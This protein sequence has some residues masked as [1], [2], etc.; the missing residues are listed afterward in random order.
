MDNVPRAP[1]SGDTIVAIATSPGRGGVGIV[2]VSGPSAAPIARSLLGKLPRPRQ[3]TLRTFRDARNEILDEGLVLY[4][5]GP[6]SFTGE[7][8]L[9]LH[10]HGGPVV[11]DMLVARLL[12]LGARPARPGEFSERA[13]LNGK[14]D[15]IQAEAVADLIA[16][17]SASAARAALRSL[18]GEFSRRVNTIVAD[19]VGLRAQVEAAIDFPEEDI[20]VLGD[21][22][23][24]QQCRGIRAA[25]AAL[26]VP[27]RQGCLLQEGMT[28]VLVGRPNSGKSSLLNAL[29]RYD[30][31]IVSAIPGTTRD[32]LREQIDV[33]GMPLH[34][35][36]T[37]GLRE[38]GD[39]IERE[40]VRR[41]RAAAEEADHVLL[42]VDDCTVGDPA[43]LAACIPDG[44]RHTLVRNK[45]DIT[46][47]KPGAQPPGQHV[48]AAAGTPE[49]AI[50]AMT[51]AGIDALRA[52]LKVCMGFE[53]AGETTFS[54][55]RRHI[56]ALSRAGRALES[57]DREIGMRQGELAAEE[58]RQAQR[59]LDEIT[60][61]LTSDDLL[62]RIFET[63]CIGK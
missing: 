12:E 24:L 57:A 1:A 13:F 42:V 8:V 16:S 11:L 22:R 60:G 45:I 63:F 9:E 30:R 41:A 58:L 28:V 4:F 14:M 23:L 35:V 31:A 15:L 37:A 2:R 53:V 61:A 29:A 21:D 5:P 39:E 32:V 46:G 51:G 40:G 49:I 7:D 59:A 34:L 20:D 17:G 26:L 50:S 3:A 10:G 48:S 47:R 18:Q 36:D 38:S 25:I 43:E 27:A 19:L 56:D 33:D 52:H 55:R 54:A 6:R 44:V 62:G